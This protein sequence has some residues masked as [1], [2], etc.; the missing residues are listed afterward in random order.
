[1]SSSLLCSVFR[2]A[3]GLPQ[4]YLDHPRTREWE[5]PATV[6]SPRSTL[7]DHGTSYSDSQTRRSTSDLASARFG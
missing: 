6:S 1:M 3:L 7:S 5:S 4:V 2:D